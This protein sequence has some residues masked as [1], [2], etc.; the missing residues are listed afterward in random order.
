MAV[1]IASLP[2]LPEPPRVTI[3]RIRERAALEDLRRIDAEAF[4]TPPAVSAALLDE[5]WLAL[6]ACR[7]FSARDGDEALGG[8]TAWLLAG[9]VGVFGVCVMAQARRRGIG[10]ALTVR[11][12]AAFG[13][14]A[15][16][17]W[18]NPSASGRAMYEGLG[19]RPVATS[20]VWIR[21]PA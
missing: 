17:A 20:E 2:D 10:A 14:D 12:A 8:S 16:L 6:D 4:G 19:F 18:L 21:P 1:E 9:T 13:G 11:A 7:Q 5:R 3:A 15:D